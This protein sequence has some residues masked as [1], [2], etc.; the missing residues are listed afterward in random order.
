MMQRFAASSRNLLRNL[1]PQYETGLDQAR[2][3][4]R[5]VEIVGRRTSWRKD[6]TRL[7]VDSFPSSPTKGTEYWRASPT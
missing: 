4:F 3:S 2:A 7:H 5:P 1:L 6:D